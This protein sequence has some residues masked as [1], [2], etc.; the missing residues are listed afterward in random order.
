MLSINSS[1]Y[2]QLLLFIQLQLLGWVLY[3][4]LLLLLPFLILEAFLSTLQMLHTPSFISTDIPTQKAV[5][6]RV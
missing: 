6:T 3:S 4:F 1:Y 2:N 5:G